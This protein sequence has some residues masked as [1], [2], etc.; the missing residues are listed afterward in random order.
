MQPV[1]AVSIAQ[2]DIASNLLSY[3]RHLRAGN[4]RPRTIEAYS[5]A[6]LQLAEYLA[7]QGMPTDVADIHRE[8]VEAFIEDVLGRRHANGR[9]FKPATAHQRYRGCKA[10]FRW[11][12]DE[13][14]VKANPMERMKPPRMPEQPV[15]VLRDT[16]LTA[17]LATVQAGKTF[18]ERR[19]AAILR[20]F[21]STG[22]RLAEVGGLRYTPTDDTTNDVDLDQ[23]V[24]R[25]LGKGGRMRVIALDTKAIKA[26]DR[27]LRVRIK[28][29]QAGAE[30][31]WL[32]RKGRF[33]ES[34]IGQMI[35]DRGRQAGL[36][37]RIH[38][39]QL[40]HSVVHGN[41]AAGMS[42]TDAMRVYGWRSRG[43]LSRYAA[44]TGTE[45]AL[46]AQRKIAFGDRL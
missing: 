17:L 25:V 7:R 42:D 15:P 38:A 1:P 44:S 5:G 32:G 30:W 8:H 46:A 24:I 9:L 23:G 26:I 35:A 31:L 14:E 37:G 12:V 22:A 16:E 29:P 33:G 4:V 40:R 3:T 36:T 41:L 21:I 18:D 10:F 11:L 27:Y 34:G 39:H 20:T 13:G 28:H 43:M 19:D 2:G 6:I 45:R